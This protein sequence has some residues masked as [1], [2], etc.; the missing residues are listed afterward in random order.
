LRLLE[1]TL[2]QQGYAT[3]AERDGESALRAARGELPS[4]VVLDLMMP[5]MNGFEFL[6]RLRS[7]PAGRRVPVIVWT[8]K[9]LSAAE[10]EL[11]RASAQ[12]VVA[13]GH[14][15]SA[16]VVAELKAFMPQ[17]REG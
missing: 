14:G 17:R 5:G 6:D 13:K 1:A 12:A 10:T 8:V 9:D 2:K 4:A 11:L 16:A 3:H 7:E 15:G